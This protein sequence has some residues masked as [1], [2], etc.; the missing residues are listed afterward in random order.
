MVDEEFEVLKAWLESYRP[1]PLFDEAGE[2]NEAVRSL[3]PEPSK[4]LGSSP[5]ANGEGSTTTPFNMLV[6]NRMSRFQ[7]ALSVL[8]HTEHRRDLAEQKAVL[9]ERYE[10]KLEEHHRHIAEYGED[11]PEVGSWR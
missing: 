1:A 9:K 3:P 5:H 10:A 11:M 7:L 6:F 2:S 4:R 8:R